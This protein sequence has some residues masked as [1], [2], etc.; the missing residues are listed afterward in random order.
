MPANTLDS[1]TVERVLAGCDRQEAIM[2]LL[3]HEAGL[4]AMEV[5]ALDWRHVLAADGSLGDF[6]D[7]PAIATKGRSGQGR[8]PM[9]S[10]LKAA[11]LKL[12]A[13]R[14]HPRRGH[15]VLGSKGEGLSA[16]AVALRLNRIYQRNGLDATSHSGR[17]SYGTRLATMGLNAFQVQRAMRH[18]DIG[19]TKL[20]VDD[21][22]SDQA[23]VQAITSF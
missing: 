7:L 4:R 23:V 9:S 2:V 11:L 10:K 18:S 21:A 1:I 13:A 20:Y 6:I 15:V 3:G 14:R 8:I 19:T 22:M 16:N 5:A 12:S 17:R